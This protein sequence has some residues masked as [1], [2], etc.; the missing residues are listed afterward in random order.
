MMTDALDCVLSVMLFKD[1]S[2][3][4]FNNI[5]IV[6][7]KEWNE[8][9]PQECQCDQQDNDSGIHTT[10]DGHELDLMSTNNDMNIFNN[11]N[12]NLDCFFKNNNDI[13]DINNIL[14]SIEHR[15]HYYETQQAE[16]RQNLN[17]QH[18]QHQQF[19][20][21]HNHDEIELISYENGFTLKNSFWW[22]LLISNCDLNPKVTNVVIN[23]LTFRNKRN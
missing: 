5:I 19:Q 3:K 13:D 20:H 2:I 8:F 1:Q 6:I 7:F 23:T 18:C 15:Q 14:S 17:H 22:A 9:E 4:Y 12:D 11:V 16:K 21:E 10:L